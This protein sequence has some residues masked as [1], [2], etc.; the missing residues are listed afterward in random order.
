MKKLITFLFITMVA[1]TACSQERNMI[2]EQRN[3]GAYSEVEISGIYAIVL[4]EGKVGEL[5]VEAPENLMEN[6]ETKVRGNCLKITTQ[7]SFSL[8]RGN[9]TI[10]VPID[11][12]KGLT[13]NGVASVKSQKEINSDS[14]QIKINGTAS[15]NTA[16]KTPMLN[17]HIAGA[18]SA[19]LSGAAEVL[20]VDI[21]GTGQVNASDLKA[22]KGD[23]DVS[24]AGS[25]N[26]YVSDELEAV[27]RGVGSIKV[28][29]SPKVKSQ[30]IKGL[31]SIKVN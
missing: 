11:K 7:G 16:V 1:T 3:V 23:L 28:K 18:G 12:L 24:G 10:Q 21:D 2:T 15:V 5:T 22:A 30:V 17:L 20:V 27:V 26:A 9:I 19:T 25:I 29:G 8:R 31:G 4:T 13:V 6:I 14:L